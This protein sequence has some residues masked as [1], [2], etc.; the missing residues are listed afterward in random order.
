MKIVSTITLLIFFIAVTASAQQPAFT[1]KSGTI[2]DSTILYNYSR[3]HH[4]IDNMP[5]AMP[6]KPLP[7]AY[8]GNNGKGQNIYKSLIDGMP[9]LKPDS[10]FTDNMAKSYSL[11]KL[12]PQQNTSPLYLTQPPGTK[13]KNRLTPSDS[14]LLYL[15]MQ[16]PSNSEPL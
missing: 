5:N 15:Y 4:N 12:Q 7:E 16:P 1:L 14:S 13:K 11:R 2:P 3:P 8:V 6:V 10:T 9:I